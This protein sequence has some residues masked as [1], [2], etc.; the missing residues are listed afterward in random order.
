MRAALEPTAHDRRRARRRAQ[1]ELRSR[2]EARGCKALS[3]PV[4][5]NRKSEYASVDEEREARQEAT[6]EHLRVMRG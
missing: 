3:A 5:P 2:Q 4:L 1:R 6:A